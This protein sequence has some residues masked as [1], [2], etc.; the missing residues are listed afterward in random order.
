[1]GNGFRLVLTPVIFFSVSHE[2][3]SGKRAFR[4]GL[5]RKRSEIENDSFGKM[6]RAEA[7]D[8]F[9]FRDCARLYSIHLPEVGYFPFALFEQQVS[10][11]ILLVCGAIEEVYYFHKEDVM[12]RLSD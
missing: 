5:I 3:V 12:E 4:N 7:I 2:Y 6:G 11:S 9:Y 1:M 10:K 8:N